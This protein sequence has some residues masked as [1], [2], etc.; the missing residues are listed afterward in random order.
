MDLG[1]DSSSLEVNRSKSNP[2]LEAR[3][4]N[5]G[6]TLECSSTQN[7][8]KRD[9]LSKLSIDFNLV[10]RSFGLMSKVQVELAPFEHSKRADPAQYRAVITLSGHCLFEQLL[11]FANH[12]PRIDVSIDLQ[13]SEVSVLKTSVQVRTNDY[14][15]QSLW[16]AI[17]GVTAYHLALAVRHHQSGQFNF[18]G[19][20]LTDSPTAILFRSTPQLDFS[21]IRF[22]KKAVNKFFRAPRRLQWRVGLGVAQETDFLQSLK[23]LN[24][25]FRWLEVGAD[26]IW[27]D[28]SLVTSSDGTHLYLEEKLYAQNAGH[29]ISVVIDKSTLMPAAPPQKLD[30]EFLQG[31][32]ISFPL[33]NKVDGRTLLSVEASSHRSVSLYELDVDS[34]TWKRSHQLLKDFDGIDPVLAQFE[35]MN[36]VFV[37]DGQLNNFDNHLRLF[38]TQ[39]LDEPLTEHPCSPIKIGIRGSRMAGKLVAKNGKLYRFAQDCEDRYGK[40]VVV[41]EI[42]ILSPTQY[43]EEECLYIHPSMFGADVQGT[44]TISVCEKSGLIAF[45]G[46][47]VISA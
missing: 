27:A 9:W 30:I 46:S 4:N 25:N 23:Q 16:T 36:Y 1:V 24:E 2:M 32:H 22:C 33:I 34:H 45:D 19:Q 20:K 11:K 18:A 39:S 38:V 13:R 47:F 28:P 29:L 26:R 43:A 21:L 31:L 8:K 12:V 14:N 6:W 40:A 5:T 15:H 3:D 37:G 10:S 44:H 41:F 7:K 42:T 35:G 17:R